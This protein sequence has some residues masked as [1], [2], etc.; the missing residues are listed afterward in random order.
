MLGRMGTGEAYYFIARTLSRTS[1][2]KLRVVYLIKI[3]VVEDS[4]A[5]GR[6]VSFIRV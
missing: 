6:G 3:V 2:Q 1:K 5:I 4:L